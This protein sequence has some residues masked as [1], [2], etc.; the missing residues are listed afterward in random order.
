M[1]GTRLGQVP[2]SITYYLLARS[3]IRLSRILPVGRVPI[4]PERSVMPMAC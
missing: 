2:G 4:V 3:R 1:T